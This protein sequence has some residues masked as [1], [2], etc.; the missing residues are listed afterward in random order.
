ML[1]PN[2]I[3]PSNSRSKTCAAWRTSGTTS[4][5]SLQLAE[6]CKWEIE[7]QQMS[8]SLE[9][10]QVELIIFELLVNFWYTKAY[11]KESVSEHH[12]TNALQPQNK[13]L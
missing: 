2:E 11:A 6:L 4:P 10:S 3:T 1:D 9:L 13:K 7:L 12:L 8:W 5:A